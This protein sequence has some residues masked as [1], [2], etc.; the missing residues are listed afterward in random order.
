M[1]SRTNGYG[2]QRG[3]Q[4]RPDIKVKETRGAERVREIL[5]EKRPEIEAMFARDADPKASFTRAVGLAVDTYKTLSD[6]SDRPIDEH[7]AAKAALWAFQRKLDPGTE[8]YFVPYAGK[9]T[10]IVSP[11]GLIN[12][13]FRSGFVLSI[14]ARWVFQQEVDEGRFDHELGSTE[15]VKHKKGTNARPRSK[16]ESWEGLAFTYAVINL[17]GGGQIIEVHDRA[18][19]EYYRSLSKAKAGLWFDWPAEAGRKAVLKQALGR[20]PKQSEISAILAADAANES[21]LDLGKDFWDNV[22]KRVEEAGGQM[23]PAD[24]PAPAVK[25]EAGDPTKMRLP[26]GKDAPTV[27]D[28]DGAA[29]ATWEGKLRMEL[30]AGTFDAGGKKADYAT[31]YMSLMLT[32]RER[33]RAVGLAFPTHPRLGTGFSPSNRGAGELTEEEEDAAFASPPA[34]LDAEA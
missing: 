8:V 6:S 16:A 4:G 33:M 26:G 1:Q 2:Q 21:S 12:L 25:Y 30:D 3:Q 10:P 11:Q 27:A 32:I 17:K 18:D 22:E 7:S 13:A 24:A 19:I 9:V 5:E 20:C 34:H 15:W 31:W 29:L 14:Q 23:P 28:A